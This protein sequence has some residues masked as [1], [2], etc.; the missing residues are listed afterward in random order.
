MRSCSC[1]ADHVAACGGDRPRE[2]GQQRHGNGPVGQ[3]LC[4]TCESLIAQKLEL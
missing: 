3:R 1:D 2:S 4:R